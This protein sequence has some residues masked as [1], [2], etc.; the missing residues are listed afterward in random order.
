MAEPTVRSVHPEGGRRGGAPPSSR[1]F[2]RAMKLAITLLATLTL[3]LGCRTA[4]RTADANPHDPRTQLATLLS[5][6]Q[7]AHR[8]GGTCEQKRPDETPL[9]DCEQLRKQIERLAIAFPNDPDVLL[10][11]AVVA[12]EAG[13]REEAEKDLD[14]LRRIAPIQPEA[15]LL[16]ARIAIADGNLR[17]ARRMLDEQIELTPDHAGLHELSSSVLYLEERYDDAGFELELA[18]RL[19]APAWRVAYHRGLIFEATGR[20][21]EAE[22][23]YRVCLEL[24]P[25]FA[26]AGSRLRALAVRSGSRD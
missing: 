8:D 16:R 3:A 17:L 20:L 7:T 12:F 2:A 6:W 14:A 25:D 22:N 5:A 10:A 15:T 18:A 9:V 23:A 21:A 1:A 4:P 19:G 24:E 26:P 11:N 13:R